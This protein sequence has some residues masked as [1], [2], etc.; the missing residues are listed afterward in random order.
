MLSDPS[1]PTPRSTA[2]IPASRRGWQ[3]RW[4]TPLCGRPWPLSPSPASPS[5]GCVP[6]PSTYWDAPPAGRCLC[7]SGPPRPSA[8]PPSPSSSRPS[9]GA[10]LYIRFS[11]SL[12]PCLPLALS[13][14]SS[15]ICTVDIKTV[16]TSVK[17]PGFCNV[18][19]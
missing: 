1:T 19:K 8:S 7:A 16:Y 12:R 2:R 15:S 18:N 9:T 5:T 13:W 3:W 6:P 14:L 17:T 10:L 4:W 11:V